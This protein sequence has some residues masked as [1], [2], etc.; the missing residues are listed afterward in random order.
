MRTVTSPGGNCASSRS[1][2]FARYGG[3]SRSTKM[4]LNMCACNKTR[5]SA[6]IR[7]EY[8]RS[9]I[10]TGSYEDEHQRPIHQRRKS[11]LGRHSPRRH[12]FGGGVD[13]SGENVAVLLCAHR[14]SGGG[15]PIW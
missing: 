12:Y 5:A 15:N 14:Q 11:A 2:K 1:V 6:S 7:R 4:A 8:P 13:F 9:K 3:G 10:A